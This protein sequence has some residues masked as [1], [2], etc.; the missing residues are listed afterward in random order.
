MNFLSV[1]KVRLDSKDGTLEKEPDAKD[2]GISSSTNEK[3]SG[4]N[5]KENEKHRTV[6]VRR[7]GDCH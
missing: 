6:I 4:N 1:T 5:G 7:F 3:I 2:S